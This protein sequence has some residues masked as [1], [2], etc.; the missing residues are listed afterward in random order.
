MGVSKV[1]DT[2][3]IMADLQRQLGVLV[4]RDR[5]R[6]KGRARRRSAGAYDPPPPPGP[7]PTP[8]DV[9]RAKRLLRRLR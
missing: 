1:D 3:A 7:Q 2:A 5:E 9:A 4:E 8:L 6:K